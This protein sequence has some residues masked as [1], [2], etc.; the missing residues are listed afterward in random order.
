MFE[1]FDKKNLT[2]SVHSVL[3]RLALCFLKSSA[4]TE[5][6]G[7]LMEQGQDYTE[8]ASIHPSQALSIFAAWL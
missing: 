8:D 1:N 4:M 5:T 7:N 3:L 6:G 2:G